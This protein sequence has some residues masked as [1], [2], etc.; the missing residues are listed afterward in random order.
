MQKLNLTK[1]K[2]NKKCYEV[3]KNIEILSFI[4]KSKIENYIKFIISE[5]EKKEDMKKLIPYLK[6]IGLRKIMNFL[7]ILNYLKRV[8]E[9][10]III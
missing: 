3:L 10:M 2:L 6:K 8:K 4:T 1:N 7:T 9:E 5:L